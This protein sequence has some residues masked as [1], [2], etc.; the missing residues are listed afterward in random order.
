MDA[1]GLSWTGMSHY[2]NNNIQI[3]DGFHSHDVI[4]EQSYRETVG[5]SLNFNNSIEPPPDANGN[6]E[7]S[8]PDNCKMLICIKY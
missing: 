2:D 8:R 6:Y 7:E 5:D 1:N 3:T 4:F